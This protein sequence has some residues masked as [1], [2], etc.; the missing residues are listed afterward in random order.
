M[1]RSAG[2]V[3]V[4]M[5]AV[6]AG[7]TRAAEAQVPSGQRPSEARAAR[8]L[9]DFSTVSGW[10]AIPSDGTRLSIAADS[11]AMRLDFDFRGGG[12]YVIAR[13][14]IPIS[15]PSNY[16]ITFRVRAE[17]PNNNLEI[18]LVDRS[19]DNVWWVNKRDFAFPRRWTTVI[20][21][22]RHISFAWGPL[23]GGELKESAAIEIAVT[24]GT[25]GKG[26]VWIDD[27]MLTPLDPV[28]AY[29]NTPVVRATPDREA[30]RAPLGVTVN[31]QPAVMQRAEVIVRQLPADLIFRY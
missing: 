16:E 11:G 13:K 19:G 26:S 21:K 12:G 31:G 17:A 25:G 18:K 9:D 6:D 3:L 28:T 27:L 29:A 2:L 14:E 7:T 15:Y 22:K 5:V 20:L 1:R 23:G 24:A 8:V 10:T 4:A 30:D